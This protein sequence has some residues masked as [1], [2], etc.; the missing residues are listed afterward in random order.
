MA[1]NYTQL[2]VD[3]TLAKLSVTEKTNLLAGNDFW[4]LNEVQRHGIPSVRVSDGPNGVRGTKFF[5]GVKANCF[6]CSTGLGA[7]FDKPLAKKVG[8]ALGHEARAKGAHVLLGPTC[9]MQRSPLGGRGFESFAEDPHLSGMLTANYVEGV[10][11]TGVAACVKHFVANDQEFERFSS[12]S[13]VGARA[14]RE[15]YLEPFRLA[16]KHAHPLTF[17]SSYNRI[18]GIHVSESKDLLDDILRKEWGFDG[19]VMSDWTGTYSTDAAVKAGLDLEM[20]GPTTMRGAAI[21]RMLA[22]GKLTVSDI[23]AR[24]RNVLELVNHAIASGIPFNGSESLIDTPESRALLRE[25]ANSAHVLLK[26]SD[27]LLPLKHAKKIAVIG[28]NAKVPVASGGG[29]ASLASTYT[30][31]PLEGITSAAKEIGAKV[32]FANGCSTFRYLPLLDPLMKNG[33]LEA[34]KDDFLDDWYQSKFD[35]AKAP[36]PDYQCNIDTSMGILVDDRSVY[37]KL[38][39]T[40]RTRIS[41]TYT[42]ETSGPYLID[43]CTLGFGSVLIDGLVVLDNVKTRKSGEIFFGGGSEEESATIQLEKGREYLIELRHSNNLTS[44][45]AG[46]F[47][48]MPQA[49]GF[50]LGLYPDQ[51]EEVARQEAVELAKASDV[52]IVVVGT[53]KDWESEGFDRK[54]IAL[55]GA[56]DALVQAVQAANPKTIIVTQSGCP[57]SMPWIE[58]AS[59]VLQAFFGGNELGNALADIVFG[60]VNPSGKLPMTFP[61]KLEDNPSF[62]SFGITSSTPGAA[63]YTEGIYMGYR[64]YDANNIVTLFPFGFGLSYT[65]FSLSSLSR[66]PLSSQAECTLSMKVRNTGSVPGRSVVQVY[67]RAV[68]GARGVD[69]PKKE[70]IGFTKTSLLQPGEEEVVKVEVTKEAFSYWDEKKG[71][72]SVEEGEYEFLVGE[73][74]G[75]LKLGEKVEVKEA[76]D[77]RGL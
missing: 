44:A 72:W 36:E 2:D 26:N 46:P 48:A 20:P 32:E 6:P 31:S 28:A 27:S 15:I 60:K 30:V 16:V 37:A 33:K 51:P 24:V 7:S 68:G 11:S 29:S 73:N 21:G 67:V 71:S 57:V 17:M 64:H 25:A 10:Q 5:N 40:P 75:E 52:A 49:I 69:R 8:A 66:T 1:R 55:P 59:T 63:H 54:T 34:W 50:R 58:Q 65:T 22:A 35:D 19:L 62:D 56:Q 43:L 74:S 61:V 14:L 41:C 39:A 23:D 4:H 47:S 13:V 42:P 18:N 77:W 38:G 12:D 45:E 3:T 76:F 53:N 70:L 9:N